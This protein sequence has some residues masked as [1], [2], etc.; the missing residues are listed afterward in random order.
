MCCLRHVLIFISRL[1]RTVQDC[2]TQDALLWLFLKR[3]V[4][5]SPFVSML[6]LK[7]VVCGSKQM[8]RHK[9]FA[10][11]WA[12]VW[13]M[14]ITVSLPSWFSVVIE[15]LGFGETTKIKIATNIGMKKRG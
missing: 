7:S 2:D 11:L 12:V 14:T 13:E 9:F 4:Q 6:K 5:R 15:E 10:G 8:L 3:I 1:C